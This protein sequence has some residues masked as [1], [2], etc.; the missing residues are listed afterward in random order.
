[1]TLGHAAGG[2]QREARMTITLDEET[3]VSTTTLELRPITRVEARMFVA[4]HHR[5]NRPPINAVFQVGASV[6]GNIVG[7]L[8]AAQ[9]LARMLCDG[10]TLEITRVATDGYP[11]ACSKLYAAG[12]R[13][14]TALGYRRLVTY[15]LASERGT[16]LKATGWTPDGEL[17]THDALGWVRQGRVMVNLFGER[18]VPSEAKRRWWRHLT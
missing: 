2:P 13:A 7:V 1:M 14:A 12:V 18:D 11:N 5:H 8:M 17:R 15:T 4:R 16:A 9:P 3:H 10:F 6:G